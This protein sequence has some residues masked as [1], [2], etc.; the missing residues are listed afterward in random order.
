MLDVFYNIRRRNRLTDLFHGFFEHF[1][2]FC[3]FNGESSCT[4]ETHIMLL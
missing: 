2:V 3:L 1:T 4:D